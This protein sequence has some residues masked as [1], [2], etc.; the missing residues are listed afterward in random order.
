MPTTREL[1]SNVRCH[2]P[3]SLGAFG[4]RSFQDFQVE[5]AERQHNPDVD[6]QALPQLMPEEQD[7]DAHHDG[8][9]RQHVKHDASLPAHHCTLPL[10][11]ESFDR[12]GQSAVCAHC[13][14]TRSFYGDPLESVYRCDQAKES[15]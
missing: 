12:L 3:R 13:S 5:H 4:A 14:C 11:R 7:V 9:E 15:R 1:N 6:Y 2:R 8:Y 10:A